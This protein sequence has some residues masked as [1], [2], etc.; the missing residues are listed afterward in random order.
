[1]SGSA[2]DSL[3]LSAR[4]TSDGHVCQAVGCSLGKFG[5]GV[6]LEV[7]RLM[8]CPRTWSPKA[9]EECDEKSSELTAGAWGDPQGRRWDVAGE[10]TDS[11]GQLAVHKVPLKGE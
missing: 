2:L 6:R 4:K 7:K 8:M 5:Q 11:A 3:K 1:M 10:D 9:Q